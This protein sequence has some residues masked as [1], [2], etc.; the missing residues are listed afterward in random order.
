MKKN[1][2]LLAFVIIS[3]LFQNCGSTQ[4][5]KNDNFAPYVVITLMDGSEVSGMLLE[6]TDEKIVIEKTKYKYYLKENIKE[7]NRINVP[8]ETEM[9]KDIVKNTSKTTNILSIFLII[10]VIA[11]VGALASGS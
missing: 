4:S 10:S 9:M 8:A 5:L 3:L 2:Y 1:L 11:S 6:E 7:I